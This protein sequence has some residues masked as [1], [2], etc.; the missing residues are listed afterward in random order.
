MPPIDN[1]DLTGT[2][3]RRKP[4]QDVTEIGGRELSPATLMM[5]YG[6]DPMLSGGLAEAAD[7]PDHAPSPSPAP[8]MASA[9]SKG[10]PARSP[11]APTAW[12]I[13]ASTAPTRKFSRT[14]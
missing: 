6:F 13:R 8:P 7:F 5:G 10:S 12:S 4:K 14:G 11:A 2:T 1:S 3:P 9:S